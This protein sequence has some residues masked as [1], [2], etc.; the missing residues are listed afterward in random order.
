MNVKENTVKLLTWLRRK[1]LTALNLEKRLNEDSFV[2][3][4]HGTVS[5]FEE[6]LVSMGFKRNPLAWIKFNQHGKTTASWARRKSPLAHKQL[7]VTLQ[8]THNGSKTR[9]YAHREYS[10]ARHPIR[11]LQEKNVDYK[12]G[13]RRLRGILEGQMNQDRMTYHVKGL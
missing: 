2:G 6:S 4:F 8:S 10:W 3:T 5:K 7:H 13:S 9:V 11:H 1:G 12:G